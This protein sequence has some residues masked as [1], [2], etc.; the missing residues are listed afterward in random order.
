MLARLVSTSERARH[1]ADGS[2]VVS[3]TL[4]AL[5]SGSV[6]GNLKRLLIPWRCCLGVKHLLE[7]MHG[8]PKSQERVTAQ[9]DISLRLF[10]RLK[11]KASQVWYI[12]SGMKFN[13]MLGFD[14][15][16]H[17]EF[18]GNNAIWFRLAGR[19]SDLQGLRLAGP[20]DW[21]CVAR[22]NYL[23]LPLTWP[24]FR[25]LRQKHHFGC[26][27]K[28][29]MKDYLFWTAADSA[30]IFQALA[31]FA[32]ACMLLVHQGHGLTSHF[33][34]LRFFYNTLPQPERLNQK[35]R[36]GC[37]K[38]WILLIDS[39]NI[40]ENHSDVVKAEP[41]RGRSH[42]CHWRRLHHSWS[43]STQPNAKP[44]TILRDHFSR[45][46]EVN[47]Y[48]FPVGS[49]FCDIFPALGLSWL[50]NCQ[51]LCARGQ[52]ELSMLQIGERNP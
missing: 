10:R 29:E 5:L 47:S 50:Y 12:V 27:L 34:L 43:V 32:C 1:F 52:V 14:G 17:Q 13:L 8:L 37:D 49:N 31:C 51:L 2:K 15:S 44:P 39:I 19:N 3:R 26:F 46:Q 30:R 7:M 22:W 23:K 25:D 35:N 38:C 4:N 21:I 41:P 28:I 24:L 20:I 6:F 42:V 45:P 40:F 36:F 33:F 48:F 18:F 9:T 11:V 16:C